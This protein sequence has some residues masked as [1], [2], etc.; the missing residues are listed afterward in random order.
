LIVCREKLETVSVRVAEIDEHGVARTVS[1]RTMLEIAA[2]ADTSRNIAGLDDMA[3]VRYG[4]CGVVKP[5]AGAPGEYDVMWVAFAL[6][7]HKDE[8]VSAVHCNVFR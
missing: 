6:Q 2:E 1:P 3:D 7:E 5:W 4:K 8:V